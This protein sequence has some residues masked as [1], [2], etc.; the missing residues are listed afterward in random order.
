MN[1]VLVLNQ[2]IHKQTMVNLFKKTKEKINKLFFAQKLLFFVKK[3][4][5]FI[6]K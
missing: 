5:V 2:H 3:V 4:E 1:T 6:E